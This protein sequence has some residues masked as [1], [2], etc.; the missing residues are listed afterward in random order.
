MAVLAPKADLEMFA[1]IDPAPPR[2][3]VCFPIVWV[4]RDVLVFSC[5]GLLSG[6]CIDFGVA[7]L[8]MTAF[9]AC[10]VALILQILTN[11]VVIFGVVR[12]YELVWSDRDPDTYIGYTTFITLLFLAQARLTEQV[13]GWSLNPVQAS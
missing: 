12:G 13:M 11:G 5:L 2:S 10:I 6:F 7:S 3:H 9:P 8:G 4:A 1:P